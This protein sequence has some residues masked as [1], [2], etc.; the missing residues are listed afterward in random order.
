MVKLLVADAQ[1]IV[2]MGMKQL[3]QDMGG[4]SV[5]GE[6]ANSEEALAA[7]SAANFDLMV[8]D[9]GLPGQRRTGGRDA[10]GADLIN[11]IRTRYA[12]L[13]ILIFATNNDPQTFRRMMGKGVSGFMSKSNDLE[14]LATAMRRVSI[15]E[16]FLAHDIAIRMMLEDNRGQDIVLRESLTPRELQVLNLLGKGW[17]LS[18]IAKELFISGQ[19]VSTY[20]S[21]LMQKMNFKSNAELFHCAIECGKADSERQGAQ[22]GASVHGESDWDDRDASGI[23]EA[24]PVAG[25]LTSTF[26]QTATGPHRDGLDPET[27]LNGAA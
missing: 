23:N 3:C 1:C 13:P 17:S 27:D 7:L 4:F 21:R 8:L 14:T 20:K 11:T 12:S 26:G 18:A 10:G 2:R 16:S 6:A 22:G 19:T 25:E 5:E 9:P 15:G 24:V